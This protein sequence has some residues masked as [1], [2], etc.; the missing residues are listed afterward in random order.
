MLSSITV[1]V[2]GTV[3]GFLVSF[4]T[5]SAFASYTEGRRLWSNV[6]LA[7]RSFSRMAWLHVPNYIHPP[8][9]GVEVSDDEKRR[10]LVEKRSA[11]NLVAAF[12]VAVSH[13]DTLFA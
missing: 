12:S 10:A 4:R 3:L 2:F 11:I 9:D 8:A 5:S 1:T 6:I 13:L 7:S